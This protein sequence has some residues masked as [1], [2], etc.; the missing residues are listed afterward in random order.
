[1][2][3]AAE[4]GIAMR[5]GARHAFAHE[6]L[7]IL[8]ALGGVPK[9]AGDLERFGTGTVSMPKQQIARELGTCSKT[10]ERSVH[11]LLLDGLIE[12]VARTSESGAT[13]CNEYRLTDDGWDAARRLV[14]TV[15]SQ[16]Q[17]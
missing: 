14:S 15:A 11:R 3:H 7:L 13:M 12:R 17:R 16:L 8:I 6:Q 5:L 4:T 10:V 9:C 2:G 1:M